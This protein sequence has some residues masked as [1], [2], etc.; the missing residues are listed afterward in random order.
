MYKKMLS[1]LLAFAFV[2]QIGVTSAEVYAKEQTNQ[3]AYIDVSADK[4]LSSDEF[5]E[6][7]L[8]LEKYISFEDN[9]IKV[10]RIPQKE[11]NRFGSD[12]IEGMEQGI[13]ELNKSAN[14]GDLVINDNGTIYESDD[15]NFYVQGGVTKS[16][17]YWWGVKRYM[18]TAAANHYAYLCNQVRAGSAGLTALFAASGSVF[19][20]CVMGGT[21]SYYWALGNSVSY[22]NSGHSRGIIVN[23]TWSRVYTTAKQ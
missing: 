9:S 3:N 4:E 5:E 20:S 16:V 10:D 8:T 7:I 1:L 12:V 6:M 13:Q 2:L 15:D 18:S 19:A 23:M 22:R 11:K 14:K 17:K 21:A